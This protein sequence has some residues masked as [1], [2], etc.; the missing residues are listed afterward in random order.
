MISIL[1]LNILMIFLYKSYSS[2]N[3]ANKLFQGETEKISK[4]ELLKKTIYLD[5]S[6]AQTIDIR[7]QEKNE[8]VLFLQTS[9]SIHNRINPYVAYLMKEKK[10]YRLESLKPFLEYPLVAESEFV[11]DELGEVKSFRVYKSKE[12]S[13]NLYLID[14]LFESGDEILLKIKALNAS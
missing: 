12:T 5:L 3:K 7:H 8:D 14:S 10:L 13:T 2:L 11:V 9:H 1:I 6:L 4:F